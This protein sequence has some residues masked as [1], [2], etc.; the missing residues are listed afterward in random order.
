[1]LG[2][3][4][5]E[6]QPKGLLVRRRTPGTTRRVVDVLVSVARQRVGLPCPT[7]ER[8]RAGRVQQEP[9]NFPAP[10][11]SPL[12]NFVSVFLYDLLIIDLNGSMSYRF[13]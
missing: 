4:G 6:L 3:K 13:T 5:I 2:D 8:S 1:M 11:Q 10:E 9:E 7:A 12:T